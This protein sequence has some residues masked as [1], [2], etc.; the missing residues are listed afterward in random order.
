M[1]ESVKRQTRNDEGDTKA[2]EKL[3]DGENVPELGPRI[4]ENMSMEEG[5]DVLEKTL[6]SGEVSVENGHIIIDAN[7][8]LR[9]LSFPYGDSNM[10]D[11]FMR[12]DL[13]AEDLYPMAMMYSLNVFNYFDFSVFPITSI[14][15]HRIMYYALMFFLK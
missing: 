6:E 14:P 11:F 9:M 8:V 7:L 15:N 1:Q 5:M 10:F 13:K 2:F 4:D 12:E 3:V